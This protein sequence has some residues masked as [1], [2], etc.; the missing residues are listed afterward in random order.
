MRVKVIKLPN[1][2]LYVDQDVLNQ[3]GYV[4]KE[5]YSEQFGELYQI[6]FRVLEPSFPAFIQWVPKECCE[7]IDDASHL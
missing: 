2:S 4:L 3:V 1:K 5:E 6:N 7:V